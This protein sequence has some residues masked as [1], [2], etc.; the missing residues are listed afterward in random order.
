MSEE[1]TTVEEVVEAQDAVIAEEPGVPQAPVESNATDLSEDIVV[2][3]EE[4]VSE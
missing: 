2:N 4:S 3:I 1:T